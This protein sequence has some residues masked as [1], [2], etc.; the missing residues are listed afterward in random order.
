MMFKKCEVCG[1][2]F[3]T[4]PCYENT[5]RK[6]RFC[7][8]KCESIHKKSHNTIQHWEGGSVSSSTGY[9]YVTFEGGRIEEHRLV[10]MKHLGRR[11]EEGEVVHHIN[12]NR[13]DNRIENLQLLTNKEHASLHARM[14]KKTIICRMCGEEKDHYGR[15]LCHTCYHRALRKGTLKDYEQ[16]SRK[17]VQY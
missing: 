12:G 9:K 15:G 5:K 3:R 8:K 14:R 7:S 13:L 4:F 6:R 1:K 17:K 16:I 10:M 11:L 2:E